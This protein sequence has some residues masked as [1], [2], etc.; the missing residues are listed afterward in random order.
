MAPRHRVVYV[1][2]RNVALVIPE[3]EAERTMLEQDLEGMGCIGL[4]RRL[5]NIK[6]EDFVYEFVMILEK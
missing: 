2:L 3:G 6:N 4:L 1:S 5:W